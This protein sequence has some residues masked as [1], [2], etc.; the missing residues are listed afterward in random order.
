MEKR[1]EELEKEFSS[2]LKIGLDDEKVRENREKYGVNALEEKKKTSL[3][4]RFLLQFKDVLIIILLIAAAV[5]VI[6]DP[7]EFVDSLIILF[8]VIV[9]AI[10]GV[11]QENK[12]EKSLEALKSMS[13]PT[14][15]VVRTNSIIQIGHSIIP[16]N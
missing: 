4:V 1:L 8:V 2:N 13:A 6:V 9:N 11:F 12:A 7:H 15:K 14:A 5:S 10:L 16:I 3:F